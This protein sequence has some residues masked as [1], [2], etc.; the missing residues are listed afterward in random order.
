MREHELQELL[1]RWLDAALPLGSVLHHSP[2]EGKRHVSFSARLKRM[3]LRAG[4]PDLEIFSPPLGFRE[5]VTPAAI[6]LEVKTPKGRARPNQVAT[7]AALRSCGCYVFTVTSVADAEE[8]LAPLLEMDV[9][10]RASLLRQLA[11]AVNG[12]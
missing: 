6:F 7:H 3:G 11:D 10:G 8:R 5:G 9:T 1:V 12:T 4:W 2:S